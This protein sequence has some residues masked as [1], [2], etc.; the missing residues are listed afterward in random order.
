MKLATA[1]SE[2]SDIQKRLSELQERLNNNAK[3]QDGETK[4]GSMEIKECC[5]TCKYGCWHGNGESLCLYR[6][7]WQFSEFQGQPQGCSAQERRLQH[8]TGSTQY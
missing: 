7:K 3:V 6:Q 5:E 8:S 2:R 1:L 4:V